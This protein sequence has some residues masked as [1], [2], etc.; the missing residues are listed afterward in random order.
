MAQG[1]QGHRR[2]D[3]LT[4]LVLQLHVGARGAGDW[5]LT[6]N[7]IDCS[8]LWGQQRHI[9]C[10]SWRW[11]TVCACDHHLDWLATH[12]WRYV[13]DSLALG[14]QGYRRADR[15]T[16][17]VLQLRVGAR[18]AGDWQLGGDWIDCSQLWGQRRHI[19]C[20][21]WR[22]FT[23]CACDHHLDWLATHAWRY[24]DDSLALGVQ[25]Y[26]RADRLTVLVLQLRVG[27]RGAGDWQLGGD[28][29]DCSQLWGQRRHIHCCSWRWFTVCACDHH[30]DWLATHAWRY[31]D[32]SLALGVQGYRRADRLTVLVLQLHVG[33]WGTGDWQLARN[34]IDCSQLWGQ[35]R[36][37]HCCSWRW[38]TVRTGGHHLDWL[39]THAWRYVDYPLAQGIQGHRRADGLT[40]LVLQ[41]HVGARGA[42]DWK[43]T[44]N[45]IDDSWLWGQR[46]YIYRR[47]W[48]WLTVRTC[49]HHLDL[50]TTHA[51]RHIDYPLAQGIQGHRR[52][53]GLT[54][55]VL[56][57]H[58]GA[59]GT[60][61]WQLARNWIDDSWLWG[62]RRYIYRRSWRWL[63]VR[64]GGHHL[65]L[66][67]TH[68][69]RYV[70]YPLAQGIQGHRR[71]DWPAVLVLQLH[72]GA[73]GTGDWQ[74]AGDR[75]DCSR[76]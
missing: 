25:G 47:S 44:R 42:G 3:G 65:D 20:C 54:V 40:V 17:L 63:T 30:L 27:A 36:H 75:I 52:A 28:W 34:W 21:S 35:Q 31:V 60:G 45:W 1:I 9:H 48:R 50:F 23:V 49:G 69:W 70:D 57:L 68:A 15:L 66:F 29:I 56:Q 13:D 32:D 33:A 4:V 39:A 62:Q 8:Q 74:F 16:V 38:F 61:N 53:D 46:R 64:T 11:F 73:W 41:L 10:C 71:A 37:I 24:V 6:R 72:I 22:W 76:L 26:R 7:W 5:K 2:A 43:L 51:W 67:T 18:G 14:V 55:L 19:H 12:A 58:V 59:R